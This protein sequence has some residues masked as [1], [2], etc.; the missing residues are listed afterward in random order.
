VWRARNDKSGYLAQAGYELSNWKVLQSDLRQLAATAE[1]K[2]EEMNAFGEILSA[3]GELDGPNGVIL[4]VKTIWIRLHNS[5][6]T[7]FVTLI[8]DKE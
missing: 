1:A 3:R 7:R 2:S 8:P 4:E 5:D 6:D